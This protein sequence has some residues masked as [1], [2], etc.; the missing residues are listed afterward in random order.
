MRLTV[1]GV[2]ALALLVGGCGGDGGDD[3]SAGATTATTGS[4]MDGTSTGQASSIRQVAAKVDGRTLR[5]HCRG[6]PSDKPAV[7]LEIGMSADANQD[8]LSH[9]EEHL[10]GETVVC[11][12][13]RA[14]VALSDP[15]PDTPRSMTEVIA[16]ADAFFSA[17]E[18][19]PPYVLIGFSTGGAITLMYAQAHPDKV[20]GLVSIN[21]VPPAEPFLS[22]AREVQT[23]SEYRNEIGYYGGNNDESIDFAE[24]A[25]MVSDP[26]PDDLPYVVMFDEDCG[27]DADFCDRVFPALR[28]STKLLASVGSGGR[29]MYVEGGGHDIDLTRPRLTFRTIDEVMAAA[30]GR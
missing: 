7:M 28:H 22:L 23:R 27:G 18:V 21:P 9:I 17:T 26:L 29:F 14:G 13:E 6:T 4:T 15:P 19:E 3:T 25:R 11:A 1:I 8:Q 12:Y 20:A 5:G 10:E 24:T 30:S 2:C 16:D